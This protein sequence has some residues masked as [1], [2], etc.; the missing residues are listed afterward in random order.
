MLYLIVIRYI[1]PIRFFFRIKN[2]YSACCQSQKRKEYCSGRRRP[3]KRTSTSGCVTHCCP[4]CTLRMAGADGRPS[5]Y[6]QGCSCSGVMCYLSTHCVPRPGQHWIYNSANPIPFSA[7][8][9]TL[10]AALCE[11]RL[12]S[13]SV[14]SLGF[15]YRKW[16]EA[17]RFKLPSLFLNDPC[18]PRTTFKLAF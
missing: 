3:S 13:L 2:K 5:E 15:L 9:Q 1:H 14:G 8:S 10:L 17:K 4:C 11:F 7:Y 16:I 18:V 6:T 12:L